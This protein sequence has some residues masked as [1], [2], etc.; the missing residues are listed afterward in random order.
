MCVEL[1]TLIRTTLGVL[2]G[3]RKSSENV[4]DLRIY[5]CFVQNAKSHGTKRN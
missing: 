1:G 4:W 5:E 3:R 2:I